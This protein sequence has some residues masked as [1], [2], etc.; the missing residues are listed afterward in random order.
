M[1]R[2]AVDLELSQ[3]GLWGLFLIVVLIIGT[4]AFF[5]LDKI[6]DTLTPQVINTNSVLLLQKETAESLNVL[7]KSHST[8][9]NEFLS[10][11]TG[12]VQDGIIIIN[13]LE[14]TEVFSFNQTQII[15]NECK[16][17]R[18]NTI[19]GAIHSHPNGQCALSKTDKETFGQTNNLVEGVICRENKFAFFTRDNMNNPL[20]LIVE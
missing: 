5:N 3:R 17:S 10:C 16:R 7:Y 4:I 9:G 11:L 14:G 1:A 8:T 6:R 20:K 12:K 15:F 2:P 19:I 18:F 13:G